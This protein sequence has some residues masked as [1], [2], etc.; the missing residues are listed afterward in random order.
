MRALYTLLGAGVAL[1][2]FF[3]LKWMMSKTTKP[4]EQENKS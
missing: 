1:G 2:V 4:K 3:L